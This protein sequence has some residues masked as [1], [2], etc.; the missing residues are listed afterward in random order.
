MLNMSTV[1]W[2]NRPCA[3][4]RQ[5]KRHVSTQSERGKEQSAS[6]MR[7]RRVSSQRIFLPVWRAHACTR[8]ARQRASVQ[9][10]Q[11]Q[12]QRTQGAQAE[13]A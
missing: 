12:R 5:V 2:L 7:T 3:T 4:T 8:R 11:R 10:L 1:A 13:G 9:G 6:V